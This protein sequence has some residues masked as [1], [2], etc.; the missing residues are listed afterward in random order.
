[1]PPHTW[2]AI[3]PDEIIGSDGEV[4]TSGYDIGTSKN[5]ATLYNGYLQTTQ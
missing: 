4:L 3:Y 1:V 2:L 5:P